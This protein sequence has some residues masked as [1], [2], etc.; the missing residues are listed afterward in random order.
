MLAAMNKLAL[1]VM[2]LVP[3]VA[4][5]QQPKAPAAPAAPAKD[6]GK[7]A[8]A[9]PAKDAKAAPAAMP[10]M[11][12][13]PPEVKTTV[14]AFKGNWKFDSTI[15]AT[16]MPG[17]DKPIAIK[18]MTFNCK[19]VAGKQAVACDSKAKTPMGPME[20]MFV[21]AY[22]PYDKH[23]HFFGFSNM[24]EVHDHTC[25]WKSETEMT[26]DPLKGGG[27]PSGAEVTEDLSMMWTGKKEV[28]FK[29]V[30]KYTKGGATITFEGKGKR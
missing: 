5:A 2:S 1:V 17:M 22:N 4:L 6:A 10:A 27:D 28:S 11:P 14:E 20:A 26:C 23:V 18:G 15:T 7:A 3:A 16:G 8:P 12:A 9:A 30:S 19:E 13:A 25:T 29:S 21:I 24:N